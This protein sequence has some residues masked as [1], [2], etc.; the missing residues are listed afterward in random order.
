MEPLSRRCRVVIIFRPESKAI[1]PMRGCSCSKAGRERP[2]RPARSRRASSV[3]SP[4]RESVS[5]T[6]SLQRVSPVRKSRSRSGWSLAASRMCP[7]VQQAVTVMRF[8]VRVPVLSEQTTLTQPRVSTL[9]RRF[10]MVLTRTMRETLKA[11]TRVTTAGRPSGTAATAREMAVISISGISRRWRT[12]MAKSRAQR[13]TE[14]MLKTR[15]RSAR[16]C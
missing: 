15:P 14:T 13:S 8:W 1:S 11:S 10:T 12:A 9:G 6:A 3:G 16:R 5:R 7:S 2:K 4:R